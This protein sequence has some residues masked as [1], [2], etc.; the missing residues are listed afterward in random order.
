M[1]QHIETVLKKLRHSIPLTPS[2]HFPKFA[3]RR[4]TTSSRT[5]QSHGH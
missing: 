4:S 3:Q 5:S 1:A 2:A